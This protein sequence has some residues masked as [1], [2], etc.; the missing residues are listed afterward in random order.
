MMWVEIVGYAA[1]LLVVASLTQSRI[2]SLR[3][4]SLSGSLVF[5]I[6]GF[7]IASVPLVVT[8]LVLFGINAWHLWK[9]TTGREEFSLLE[10]APDS[11]YL[12]RFLEFHADDI[13][14]SQPDFS[15]VREGD[16]VVMVLRDM[17]PTLVVVGRKRDSE[18]RVFLDY[19]IP[20]YRDFKS[21]PWLYENRADFF[22]RM[23]V[24]R[25]VATGLTD[26]H[27]KYLRRAGFRKREDGKWERPVG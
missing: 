18:F 27:V 7:L 13:A 8:N 22:H 5:T 12:R 9:I 19:A 11:A 2:L 25:I 26:M 10:V 16:T 6:Y 15:G 20:Q 24:D 17:V 4:L 3:I 21:G 14:A 23:E 1:S